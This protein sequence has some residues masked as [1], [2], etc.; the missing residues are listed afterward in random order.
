VEKYLWRTDR[1]EKD[2]WRMKRR[3]AEVPAPFLHGGCADR[4]VAL[5]GGC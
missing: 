2:V 4:S 3:G 5:A 1:V